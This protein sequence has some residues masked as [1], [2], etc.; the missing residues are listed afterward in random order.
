MT[1]EPLDPVVRASFDEGVAILAYPGHI[2][3]I[4]NPY[5]NRSSDLAGMLKNKSF[6]ENVPKGLPIFV[7]LDEETERGSRDVDLACRH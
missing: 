1:A 2:V 5:K 7:I 6:A 3:C 4:V